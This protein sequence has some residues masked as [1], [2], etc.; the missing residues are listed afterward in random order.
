MTELWVKVKMKTPVT[1]NGT[2]SATPF[3]VP[4]SRPKIK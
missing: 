2:K 1:R 3:L 4:I